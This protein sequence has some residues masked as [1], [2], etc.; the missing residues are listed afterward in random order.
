MAFYYQLII[1][2]LWVD[3]PI[4]YLVP[5]PNSLNY[6]KNGK[7]DLASLNL[8]D[9]RSHGTFDHPPCY[10]LASS[11]I[12]YTLVLLHHNQL[13]VKTYMSGRKETRRQRGEI[14]AANSLLSLDISLSNLKHVRNADV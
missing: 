9:I 10:Q 11:V 3:A 8:P 12:L 7:S 13:N 14:G 5:C 4:K 2:M 6:G 1:N